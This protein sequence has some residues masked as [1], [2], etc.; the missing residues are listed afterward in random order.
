MTRELKNRAA[1]DKACEFGQFFYNA[2]GT[3]YDSLLAYRAITENPEAFLGIPNQV[4]LGR[5]K[6]AIRK[7]ASVFS[8]QRIP[9]NLETI[10]YVTSGP[11]IFF[12]SLPAGQNERYIVNMFI[13]YVFQVWE[14]TFRP[15][16]A[17]LL[18]IA[19][20]E[21]RVPIM[22]DLC[23]IRNSLLHNHGVANKDCD[24]CEVIS[25]FN[26]GDKIVITSE[27]LWRIKDHVAESMNAIGYE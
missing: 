2:L 24:R 15:A 12:R 19:T 17:H 7:Y 13:V 1:H 9:G 3:I 25:D 26:S 27:L 21:L 5:D 4:A 18:K 10:F 14:S 20:K 22:G 23:K 16:I 8:F 11:D 6:E